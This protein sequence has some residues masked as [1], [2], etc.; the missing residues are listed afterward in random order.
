MGFRRITYY[1]DRPD[2]MAT[3]H[4]VR[5]EAEKASYPVLLSNGNLLESGVVDEE[6]HYSI[7]QDPFPKPSYLFCVVAGNLGSIQD[8]YTTMSG[9]KVTLKIFSEPEN[10]SKLRYAMQS[11]KNSM[12]W[13]EDTFGLEYDLDLYN[14]VAVN[15]FNMGAMENKVCLRRNLYLWS[16]NKGMW[17]IFILIHSHTGMHLMCGVICTFQ[18]LNV[19]NTAYVLA[20]SDSATDV[21]Y[22]RV[23]SVIGH[24]YFHNWT[25]NRVTCRDWFQLTLKEG[26]TV[27]RDQEFSG[28]MGS[29][30]VKRIETVRGLRARQFAEDAGPMSHPI[31]P[32]SYISMDNFYTATVYVKG[33]GKC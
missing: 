14:I 4:R 8:T 18:G 31:R 24:E 22:E 33:S 13:D 29:K 16:G 9:R 2:N 26:L 12:K 20:N 15:D 7:W 5:I 32:D 23:E 3:F 19:F 10:V 25:G 11:L 21:D 28:D 17:I 6:R 27:F 1:P 30:A